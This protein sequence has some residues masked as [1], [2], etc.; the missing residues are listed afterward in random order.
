MIDIQHLPQHIL[1]IIFIYVS[2]QEDLHRCRRVCSIWHSVATRR[3]FKRVV[4]SR[5]LT[6]FLKLRAINKSIRLI[7]LGKCIKE[8]YLIKIL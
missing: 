3:L 8:M 2:S 5:N 7:T 1:E 4:I 6:E